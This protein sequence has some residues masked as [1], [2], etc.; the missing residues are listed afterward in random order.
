MVAVVIITGST[1]IAIASGGGLGRFGRPWW[2]GKTNFGKLVGAAGIGVEPITYVFVVGMAGE[3]WQLHDA[4]AGDGAMQLLGGGERQYPDAT[5]LRSVFDADLH[6]LLAARISGTTIDA[7][8]EFLLGRA[9]L[10]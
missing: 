2:R 8:A 5:D 1:M 4:N 6:W 3:P 9:D 10:G 7:I